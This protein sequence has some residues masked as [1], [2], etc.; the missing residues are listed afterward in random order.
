M[1]FLPKKQRQAIWLLQIGAF[2]DYFDLMLYIH[3]AVILNEVFF[4]KTGPH[5]TALLGAFAFCST[6]IMRPFGALLF[7]YIGDSIGRKTAIVISTLI[8]SFTCLIMASLPPY[9]QIGISA[10]WIVTLCRIVQG[11]AS[12]GETKG[13]D[14]YLTEITKPP[15]QYLIV[16]L[17]AISST[18]GSTIALATAA[19]AISYG[20]NWRNAF[21]AGAIIAVVGTFARTRLRETPDFIQ[22]KRKERLIN[23]KEKVSKKTAFA[24]FLIYC[25]WP[26]C[27][28]F[29]FIF[30]GEILK[31]TWGYTGAQIIDHNLKVSFFGLLGCIPIT[32]MS[33]WLH[34]LK[35][36]KFKVILFFGF[37]L[38]CPYLLTLIHS[39]SQ[40]LLVQ[41][42]AIFFALA[43]TPA[44][45]VFITHFPISRR[46]TYTSLLYASERAL[47]SILT[48]FGITYLTA[49]FGYWG[50]SLIMIPIV[51][52]FYWGIRHF[53]RLERLKVSDQ[54]ILLN[55][56]NFSMDKKHATL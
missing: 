18:V 40:L 3:M 39:P 14:I 2:L 20:F 10:A 7:G 34:P 38:I 19:L 15:M 49:W 37:T 17:T 4:P 42:F 53:E 41:S 46:F 45:A 9:Q 28:Y 21:W 23:Q 11:I 32:F 6:Y 27:F 54:I 25:A 22:A 13:A 5:T 24:Y 30:C 33:Y 48:S 1:E 35:I 56:G 29:S 12:M 36:L 43:D 55:E 26:L 47:M 16:S 51:A 31:N 8:M 50:I 52:G 44:T